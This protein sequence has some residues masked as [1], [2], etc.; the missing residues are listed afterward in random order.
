ML[1]TSPKNM[2][3]LREWYNLLN[4]YGKDGERLMRIEYR[5]WKCFWQ[6]KMVH[7][8]KKLNKSY[9]GRF[10]VVPSYT[11]EQ[12]DRDF[13]NYKNSFLKG[14][15]RMVEFERNLKIVTDNFDKI[16]DE[17][18]K[19]LSLKNMEDFL[20]VVMF[21][22]AFLGPRNSVDATDTDIDL[23][24][25]VKDKFFEKRALQIDVFDIHLD[26]GKKEIQMFFAGED[27]QIK[28]VFSPLHFLAMPHLVIKSY[29]PPKELEEIR[30]KIV[31]Q[32]VSRVMELEVE[33]MELEEDLKNSKEPQVI[34]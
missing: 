6:L 23:C 34:G 1:E 20:G 11:K 21:G 17:V 4:P 25:I 28:P 29:V 19:Q 31:K 27:E 7:K 13:L 10:R 32:T 2:S 24:F 9:Q 30:N 15:P 14:E 8:F 16:E 33:V 5:F 18:R 3:R 26:G 22:S 12:Q